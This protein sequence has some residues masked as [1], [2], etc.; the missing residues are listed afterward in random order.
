MNDKDIIMNN[1][2]YGFNNPPDNN[3]YTRE[4]LEDKVSEFENRENNKS[5][6]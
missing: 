6:N 4:E 5:F 2:E 1:D 3:D